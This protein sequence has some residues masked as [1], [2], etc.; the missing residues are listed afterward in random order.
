M[1]L[2]SRKEENQIRFK[3]ILSGAISAATLV[4]SVGMFPVSAAYDVCDVNRDGTVNVRDV[5]FIARYLS[6]SV[7]VKD[8]NRLD[9]NGS[10][11][12]DSMDKECVL[13]EVMGYSY[14][15]S[16]YSKNNKTT[17]H[18]PSVST[19]TLNEAADENISRAY[20]KYTY[21]NGRTSPYLLR[22][23]T[24]TV[25]NDVSTYSVIGED[26]RKRITGTE[27]TGIA[28]LSI[29]GTGF[30]IGDHHIATA[31]HCVYN[32]DYNQWVGSMTINTYNTNGILT[33][34]TLTPIE[35]HIP[36][37]YIDENGG[38]QY[39]Y[40]YALITV[41]EDLSDYFQ[42]DLGTSYS[43]TSTNFANIPIY[44]TGCPR[45]TEV[46]GDNGEDRLLY[47]AEGRITGTNNTNLL[48]YN[49]DTSGGNSGGPVYTVTRNIINNQ[50]VYSY[51]ALAI[52][53]YGGNFGSLITKYHLHFLKNN[54]R[55][56]WEE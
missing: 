16:Y 8:Y 18:A 29:G 15:S 47:S 6:A 25:T 11:T 33:G 41:E 37:L 43:V 19:I 30:I 39:K 5:S 46:G 52:H 35:A 32:K 49:T 36:S 1:P 22:P 42:F 2:K 44:V 21:S 45:E 40:D 10:L 17:S 3:K 48:H 7:K 13:A 23:T 50:I 56:S 51:T 12:I 54:S 27:C 20:Y 53:A 34:N 4:T 24:T 38:D 26:E 14:S 31:A 55:A 28:Q 9:V